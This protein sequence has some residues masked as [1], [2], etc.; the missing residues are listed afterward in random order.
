VKRDG[1]MILCNSQP[2][3]NVVVRLKKYNKIIKPFY[4]RGPDFP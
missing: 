3:N 4:Q 2:G 1:E